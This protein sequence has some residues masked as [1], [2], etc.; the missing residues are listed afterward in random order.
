MN[1]SLLRRAALY[2]ETEA[3][4]HRES[5]QLGNPP[6]DWACAGCADSDDCPT[7]KR[8]EELKR[9]AADLRKEARA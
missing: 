6:K 1:R 9:V 2:I 4:L 7:K 8:Y 3:T 5:C